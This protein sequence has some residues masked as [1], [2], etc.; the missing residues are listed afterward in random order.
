MNLDSAV[1]IAAKRRKT[2]RNKRNG[3]LS[4]FVFVHLAVKG[5]TT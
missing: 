2:L 5:I 3:S 4:R 1:G